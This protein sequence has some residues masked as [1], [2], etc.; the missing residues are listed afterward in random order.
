M[1]TNPKK[2]RKITIK[3]VLNEHELELM[4]ITESVYCTPVSS[5]LK[6]SEFLH[7]IGNRVTGES[8]ANLLLNHTYYLTPLK[9]VK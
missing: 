4:G 5:E 2:M 9:L 3:D 7:D 6:V 1:N 8:N